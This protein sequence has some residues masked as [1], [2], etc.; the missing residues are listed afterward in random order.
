MLAK[1]TEFVVLTSL[2][3]GA[4]LVFLFV[5]FPYYIVVNTYRFF[6]NTFNWVMGVENGRF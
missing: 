6:R 1:W 5:I 3:F 2:F 4:C